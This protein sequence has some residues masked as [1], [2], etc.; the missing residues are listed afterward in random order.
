MATDPDRLRAFLANPDVPEEAKRQAA[1]LYQDEQGA[2]TTTATTPGEGIRTGLFEAAGGT[3]G[4]LLGGGPEGAALGTV[5]GGTAEDLLAGRPLS[6]RRSER[7][8]MQG[9]SGVA[10]GKGISAG[11]KAGGEAIASRFSS[12]A[13]FMGKVGSK[14]GEKARDYGG[15]ALK[16]TG[17][18]G[19]S[20]AEAVAKRFSE[21]SD[22]AF[23]HLNKLAGPEPIVP[24]GN[25]Q[26]AAE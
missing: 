25:I 4:E 16:A 22:A 8:A 19:K 20:S 6:E 12:F 23:E 9:A 13:E 1:R 5:A 10:I 7:R 15:R 11:A 21:W 2:T 26:A 18:L 14:V 17:D 3:A 24:T